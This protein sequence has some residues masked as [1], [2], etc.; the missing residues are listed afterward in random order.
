MPGCCARILSLNSFFLISL[1]DVVLGR[2]SAAFVSGTSSLR[3]LL[4]FF[5]RALRSLGTNLGMLSFENLI[6]REMLSIF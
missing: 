5:R 4:S 1:S 6:L 2:I 3:D